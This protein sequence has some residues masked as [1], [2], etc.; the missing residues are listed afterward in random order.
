MPYNMFLDFS[1]FFGRLLFKMIFIGLII[2]TKIRFFWENENI[3]SFLFLP[4]KALI[5][6]SAM[7]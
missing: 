5:H 2:Y 7:L 4:Y 6:F 1:V 3:L